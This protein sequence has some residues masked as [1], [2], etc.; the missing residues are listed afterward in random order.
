MFGFIVY[1]FL[2]KAILLFEHPFKPFDSTTEKL[3]SCHFIRAELHS[4]RSTIYCSDNSRYSPQGI[5]HLVKSRFKLKLL[6]NFITI[7]FIINHVI[8]E[9]YFCNVHESYYDSFDTFYSE[10]ND[11][12]LILSNRMTRHYWRAKPVQ[13]DNEFSNSHNICPSNDLP[14][15]QRSLKG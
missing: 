1:R 13:D 11:R 5:F 10:N 2:F 14:I 4:Q 9:M 8:V 15:C 12:F 3:N 6:Q 7:Q